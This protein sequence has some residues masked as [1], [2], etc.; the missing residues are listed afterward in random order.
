[1]RLFC[2]VLQQQ[3]C[4]ALVAVELMFLQCYIVHA[5]C[6]WQQCLALCEAH[7]MDLL[8]AQALVSLAKIHLH[9]GQHKRATVLCKGALAQVILYAIQYAIYYTFTTP[10]KRSNIVP[11]VPPV[12]LVH[13]V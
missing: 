7:S 3:C 1:M 9:S 5:A 11:D 12:V 6:C 2:V 4:I 10:Y 13:K 8:H